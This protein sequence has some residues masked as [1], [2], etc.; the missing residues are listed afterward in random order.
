MTQLL[1]A[2]I[3][4]GRTLSSVFL[5]KRTSYS[6]RFMVAAFVISV[7]VCFSVTLNFVE[8]KHGTCLTQTLGLVRDCI[9]VESGKLLLKL[10]QQVLDHGILLL[11]VSQGVD[12]LVKTGAPAGP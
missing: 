9:I 10:L 12:G 2:I 4:R 11:D 7:W 1:I 8:I 3:I 6:V 5:V